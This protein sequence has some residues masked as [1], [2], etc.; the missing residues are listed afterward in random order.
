MDIS[1]VIPTYNRYNVLQRALASVHAQTHKP[2][3]VII[4]DDG[5]TD[6]TSQILKLFPDVKYYYQE[7]SGVSSAR[8]LGIEKSNFEWIAFLDSDDEWHPDK[9]QEHLKLHL[10]KPKLQISYTDEKWIRNSKEVK[11]PKKYR[12]FGG[13]I[14]KKCLSHCIIAPSATL[15]HKDLLSTVGLFDESL[16]VCEDYDLWLRVAIENEIGLIDKKLI[17]KYG[18]DE[19]QLSMKFWGMDRFRVK[20]LEKLLEISES[21]EELIKSMLIEK[22]SLLLKGAQKHDKM[23]DIYNYE[24][25]IEELEN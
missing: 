24:K 16:E 5:S 15:I 17:T 18:G 10:E 14:F 9:L 22:Y 11:L 7:N 19:D 4:I 12:K 25:K 8:N 6:K 20:A 21:K 1:V 3:E 23:Q 13:E 2:K